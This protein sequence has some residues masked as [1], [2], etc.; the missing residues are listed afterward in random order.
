M[1]LAS[2]LLL[3]TGLVAVAPE[4]AAGTPGPPAATALAP[5]AASPAVPAP[6]SGAA[7]SPAS[8]AAPAASPAAP[9]VA[10]PAASSP[11]PA[12]TSPAAGPAAPA[13]ATPST[14]GA[15][16]PAVETG[17]LF[18][19]ANSAYEA[20]DY[21][22]AVRAYEELL[23]RGVV[24]G[25]LY[26]DLGNAYLRNGELGR[27]VAAYR[28]SRALLPRDQDVAAN[29]AFA[30]KSTQDALAPPEPSP[31][32]TTLFFWHYGLSRSECLRLV[33]VAN[34]L[35]WLTLAARLFRRRSEV[36]RWTSWA[37]IVVVV[38]TGASLAV[39]TLAPRR[40]AVIVPQEIDA[41]AGTRADTVV[42]FKLHAGTEVA[43]AGE[44]DGWLR[45]A[46]PDGQQG[47]IDAQH[48]EVTP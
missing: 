34:A 46:L 7:A 4:P 1:P 14:P 35:L 40:V 20:G 17:E 37:L 32:A 43:V 45:I 28:R 6:S 10:Y 48:A 41:H 18:L 23:S 21:P 27:A 26:Y 38:A 13:A 30:R 22:R 36:L 11:A 24:D 25:H 9:G 39:R 15:A 19:Q 8:P 33:V 44:R 2:L 3:V 47:W 12:V 42:R 31:I 16:A 29:L 5:P